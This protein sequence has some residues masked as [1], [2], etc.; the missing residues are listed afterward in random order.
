[1]KTNKRILH[2]AARGRVSLSL[3]SQEI[4]ADLRDRNCIE[5]AGIDPL[6][7]N[8]PSFTANVDWGYAGE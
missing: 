7:G 8:V 5:I 4:K 2:L 1:M 3:A 6:A